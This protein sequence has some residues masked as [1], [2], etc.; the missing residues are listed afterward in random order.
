MPSTHSLRFAFLVGAAACWGVGTVV[1]KQALDE[2]APFSL[3]IVQLAVSTL[4]LLGV[5]Q[6]LHL[7]FDWSPQLR[8][9]AAL[10]VLN[11]GIAYA[12]A[13]IGLAR[14]SASMSVLIWAAEPALILVLAYLLLRERLG[15]LG[16]VAVATAMFGVLLVVYQGGA[17]GDAVGVLVTFAAVAVCAVYT[18][19]TRVLLIADA[20]LT[21]T[22][23]QQVAALSF[24][25]VAATLTQAFGGADISFGDVSAQGWASAITSG[26]LY[27]AL[28]FW[29]YLSGLRHVSASVAGSFLTLIPVFGI[30]A[31]LFVGERLTERQWLG[32]V[33]VVGGVTAIGMLQWSR[34]TA[35]TQ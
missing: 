15:A 30:A 8:R 25:I 9:L 13:L 3:L 20:A 33:L 6:A 10:G 28:A 17:S 19:V 11:P 35:A 12:L 5:V 2:F 29:L 7:R 21:V 18:I 34:T 14:I 1:S 31:A 16:V 24:A 23:V 26:L 27:Y 22:L 32:A 4:F